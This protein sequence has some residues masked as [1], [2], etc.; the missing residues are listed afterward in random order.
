LGFISFSDVSYSMRKIYPAIRKFCGK[1][2]VSAPNS[3]RVREVINNFFK[4]LV[5]KG[6]ISTSILDDFTIKLL[7][8]SPKIQ[9]LFVNTYI[10]KTPLGGFTRHVEHHVGNIPLKDLSIHLHQLLGITDATLDSGFFSHSNYFEAMYNIMGKNVWIQDYFESFKSTYTPVSLFYDEE[11]AAVEEANQ[12]N[13]DA[14]GGGGGDAQDIIDARKNQTE[15]KLYKEMVSRAFLEKYFPEIKS[16]E[17][18]PAN[19]SK[20]IERILPKPTLHI[21]QELINSLIDYIRQQGV[22]YILSEKLKAAFS[23][24]FLVFSNNILFTGLNGRL[25]SEEANCFFKMFITDN[26]K[27]LEKLE[28]ID[29]PIED[30]CQTLPK[31]I[32]ALNLK[33]LNIHGNI[34]LPFWIKNLPL[35]EFSVMGYSSHIE[36]GTLHLISGVTSLEKLVLATTSL[37]GRIPTLLGNLLNLKKLDLSEND[38]TGPIPSELGKLSK[39]QELNLS[40]NQLTGK[41]PTELGSLESLEKEQLDLSANCLDKIIG[42]IPTELRK[43]YKNLEEVNFLQG[44]K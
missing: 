38:L 20:I 26:K 35:K 12:P 40:F 17:S 6:G 11:M 32:K 10:L 5:V 16:G 24:R 3:E 42:E 22:S 1:S 14:I 44:E 4:N 43:F 36:I 13:I 41:I 31:A 37:K 27:F 28:A 30:K 33:I 25:S 8:S 9:K 2:H 18:F 19:I 23:G 7:K 21:L 34:R 29:Y 15:P 39:L